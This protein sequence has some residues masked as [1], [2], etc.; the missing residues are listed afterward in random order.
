MRT[1]APLQR[2]LGLEPTERQWDQRKLSLQLPA[3]VYFVYVVIGGYQAVAH[4]EGFDVSVN[5][6]D[7]QAKH[8]KFKRVLCKF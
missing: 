2:L 1:S 5:V 3:P 7:D 8:G 4:D 6:D